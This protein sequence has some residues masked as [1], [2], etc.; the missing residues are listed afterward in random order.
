MSFSGGLL[1]RAA[2]THVV[3]ETVLLPSSRFV[4]VLGPLLESRLEIQAVAWVASLKG[5]DRAWLFDDNSPIDKDTRILFFDDDDV[6]TENHSD[7]TTTQIHDHA[8]AL[9]KLDKRIKKGRKIAL[10][11]S[12]SRMFTS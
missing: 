3:D 8:G 6:L 11:K 12:S 10:P 2:Y 7:F 4:S 5:M 1:S 9:K